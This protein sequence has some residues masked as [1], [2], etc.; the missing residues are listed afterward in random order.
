MLHP[1]GKSLTPISRA[2]LP[3]DLAT[4]TSS[5]PRSQACEKIRYISERCVTILETSPYS[6]A[7]SAPIQ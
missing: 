7:S 4:E 3:T 6:T 2:G 1:S 5:V